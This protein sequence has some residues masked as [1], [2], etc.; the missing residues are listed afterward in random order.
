M[1]TRQS[2]VFS[3]QYGDLFMINEYSNQEQSDAEAEEEE[4]E[5]DDKSHSE[6]EAGWY[7]DFSL[8]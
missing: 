3:F 6:K 7:P 2:L 1:N 8:T 4:E 5:D